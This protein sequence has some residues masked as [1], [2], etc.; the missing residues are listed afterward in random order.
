MADEMVDVGPTG[1]TSESTAPLETA[2]TGM[3]L[4]MFSK[5]PEEP[6][7]QVTVPEPMSG[8]LLLFGIV[9]GAFARRRRALA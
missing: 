5:P 9:Y 1:T 3:S 7:P 6:L 4:D 2:S 8:S